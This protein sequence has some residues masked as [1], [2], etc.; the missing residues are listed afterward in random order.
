MIDYRQNTDEVVD[1]FKNGKELYMKSPLFNKVVQMLVRRESP[2]EVIQQLIQ[3]NEDSYNAMVAYIQRDT[4]P[5]IFN[6]HDHINIIRDIRN[7]T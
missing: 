2:Y 5:L 3:C 4:R 1:L 7:D 6:N